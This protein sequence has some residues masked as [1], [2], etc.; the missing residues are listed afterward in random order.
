MDRMRG[1]SETGCDWEAFEKKPRHQ[2]PDLEQ[3]WIAIFLMCL[4]RI[5]SKDE[6]A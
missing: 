3:A 1:G 4:G 5:K 2:I 6:E